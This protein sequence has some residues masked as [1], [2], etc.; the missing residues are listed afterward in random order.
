MRDL[1]AK[2]IAR[3]GYTVHACHVPMR[4]CRQ[5]KKGKRVT[6]RDLVENHWDEEGCLS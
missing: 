1:V 3:E 5:E 2:A 4:Y 6:P